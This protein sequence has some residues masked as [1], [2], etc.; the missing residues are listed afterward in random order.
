MLEI[1]FSL[2]TCSQLVIYICVYE[3]ETSGSIVDESVESLTSI[4]SVEMRARKFIESV[5]G[6]GSSSRDVFCS[7]SNLI[8]CFNQTGLRK[9]NSQ[10]WCNVGECLS[11]PVV[12]N[13]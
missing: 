2:L 7:Y 4:S 5:G 6:D 3:S 8:V 12:D 9:K 10:A 11:Y 1:R 13:Q